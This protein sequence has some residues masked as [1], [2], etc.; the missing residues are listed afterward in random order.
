MRGFLVLLLCLLCGLDGEVS[1]G[2]NWRILAMQE[3]EWWL[4]RGGARFNNVRVDVV[5]GIH[6]DGCGVT[7]THDIE[8]GALVV[9]IPRRLMVTSSQAAEVSPM[10]AAMKLK[11]TVSR[12]VLMA[13]FL[14]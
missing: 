1:A 3:M 9:S 7:A 6:E 13:M 11:G 10:V 5:K 2:S 12:N 4:L 8:A 14:L